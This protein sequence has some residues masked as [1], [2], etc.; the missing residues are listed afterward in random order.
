MIVAE[1]HTDNGELL[2]DVDIAIET[3]RNT[4]DE[5]VAPLHYND[6]KSICKAN[7]D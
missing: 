4:E 3:D 1:D 5:W 6:K 2:Y 7:N